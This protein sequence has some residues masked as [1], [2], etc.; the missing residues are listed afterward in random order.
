MQITEL[1]TI[2]SIKTWYI[3]WKLTAGY[4]GKRT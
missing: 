2:P 4:Y 1:C 3:K